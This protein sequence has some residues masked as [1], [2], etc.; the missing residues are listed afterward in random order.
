MLHKAWSKPHNG[1]LWN[2]KKIYIYIYIHMS[3][4]CSGVFFIFVK[5]KWKSKKTE[6][7][8]VLNLP[9]KGYDAKCVCVH[10]Y[11]CVCTHTHTYAQLYLYPNMYLS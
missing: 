11:M 2:C 7:K 1:I 3:R 6:Q 10:T 5:E 9:K 8:T 4:K